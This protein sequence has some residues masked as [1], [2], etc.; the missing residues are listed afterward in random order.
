MF[1]SSKMS[2]G[3]AYGVKTPTG[4]YCA[5]PWFPP[6][7]GAAWLPVSDVELCTCAV[8]RFSQT[9]LCWCATF[10]LGLLKPA[11]LPLGRQLWSVGLGPNTKPG[12]HS[13]VLFHLMPD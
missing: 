5:G 13:G 10:W 9:R 4:L 6:E 8:W 12:S 3:C 7:P 1:K 2:Y 11:R